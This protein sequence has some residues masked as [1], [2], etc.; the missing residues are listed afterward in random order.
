MTVGRNLLK[1]GSS[2]TA[3]SLQKLVKS[4][5]ILSKSPPK[6]WPAYQL[7]SSEIEFDGREFILKPGHPILQTLDSCLNLAQFNQIQA[8]LITL[9]LFQ[10]P[11]AAGRAIK[12]LSS[13]PHALNLAIS[14]L[15]KLE[16]PDAFMCNTIIRRFVN[17]GNPETALVL[18]HQHLIGRCIVPNHYSYPLMIK[19]CADVGSVF[20]GEKVHARGLKSGD[21]V[22]WNCLIDGCARVGDVSAARKCFDRI[23]HRNVISWNTM[24]A[25]YVRC[26]EYDK[27]VD[28]FDGM[29]QE[30]ET[31]PNEATIVSVLTACGYLGRL[32]QGKWV[33]HYIESNRIIKPDVLLSTAL[34]TMYIKCGDMDMAK[35][36]F[37][38]MSVKNVVSWNSM[39]MGY[40][41]H[42]L[43]GKALEMFL[44]MEKSGQTPNDATFVCVL[45]ACAHAGMVLEGW[46]YFD[47]MHRV[48]KIEP[49]VEHY[50]CMVDLLGRAGLLKD[51]EELFKKMP[52]EGGSALWG[53][54]LSA[55]HTHSNS[56]LGEFV[57][58]WL[59]EQDPEDIGPYLLLSNIYA[60]EGRWQ[61]V[62]KVRLLIKEKG[63][64]KV[65]GSSAACLGDNEPGNSRKGKGMVTPRQCKVLNP[66]IQQLCI[67][68]EATEAKGAVG[69][70]VG[71]RGGVRYNSII[72]QLTILK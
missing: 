47:I 10:H 21:V 51:T 54:L 44:E 58:K 27:C 19:A 30:G 61:D 37:D 69:V 33:H 50:G 26:K 65:A 13:L 16:E 14:L 18:Y 6:L 67:A 48:Y 71:V 64:H 72:D 63:L 31:R 5:K 42:G 66:L 62:D 60:A 20:D 52:M 53:A 7:R 1:P 59:I 46:W 23:P 9:G 11:L 3:P 39:I 25:L 8:Q 17:H 32:D 24:L 49:K 57:A 22:S 41:T 70:G 40:G 45:A 55:C 28:M 2:F 34:L 36:V 43:G 56:Q 38:S 68:M 35:N 12:K 29:V 15:E 4:Q